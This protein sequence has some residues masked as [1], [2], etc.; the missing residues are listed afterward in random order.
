MWVEVNQTNTSTFKLLMN[1]L[2]TPLATMSW[3]SGW[4]FPTISDEALR[5]NLVWY[6]NV[7]NG[8]FLIRFDLE[9]GDIVNLT[10]NA[11]I[12]L[13]RYRVYSK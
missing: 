11:N 1:D 6:R 3:N 10:G 13:V 9:R 4:Y 8:R 5:R 7:S 2:T 12:S